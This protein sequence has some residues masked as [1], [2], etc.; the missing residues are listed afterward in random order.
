MLC[1][2]LHINI[3]MRHDYIKATEI[4]LI[5]YLKLHSINQY[6][7]LRDTYIINVLYGHLHCRN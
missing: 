4:I 2:G 5:K 3:Q 6:I 1:T 7:I